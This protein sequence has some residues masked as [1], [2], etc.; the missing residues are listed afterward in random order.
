ML[1][2]KV[3]GS[4]RC[5]FDKSAFELHR[6]EVVPGGFC[7]KHLHYFKYNGFFVESGELEVTV[8]KPSGTVDKTLLKAGDSMEVA[9]REYHR[10]R[11]PKGCVAFETYWTVLYS[12]DIERETT[13]GVE[14]QQGGLAFFELPRCTECGSHMPTGESIDG[15]C[16]KCWTRYYDE[17]T[18]K[19][20]GS[21][22]DS[23][24]DKQAAE[25]T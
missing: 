23:E 12:D 16:P 3:W 7:S 14:E 2:G 21:E 10:F 24:Q 11:S 8:W 18:L 15:R 9:P 13:G 1:S 25:D 22:A 19:R 17:Q 6:I 4:T 20:A 5:L